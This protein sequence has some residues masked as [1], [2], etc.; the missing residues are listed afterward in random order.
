MTAILSWFLRGFPQFLWVGAN[1]VPVPSAV[2]LPFTQQLF[3]HLTLC[4]LNC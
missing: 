4:H 3:Y 1:A 2:L